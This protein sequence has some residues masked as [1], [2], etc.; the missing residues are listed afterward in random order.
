MG[1]VTMRDISPSFPYPRPALRVIWGIIKNSECYSSE[2]LEEHLLGNPCKAVYFGI[3]DMV[4]IPNDT[5]IWIWLVGIPNDTSWM[6]VLW[7]S[8]SGLTIRNTLPLSE[9]SAR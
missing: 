9:S 1:V 8:L 7:C 5:W 2:Y 6:R 3:M 4:G